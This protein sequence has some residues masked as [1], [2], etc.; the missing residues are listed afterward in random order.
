MG[1]EG[2]SIL[3]GHMDRFAP[4]L[5]EWNMSTVCTTRVNPALDV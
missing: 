4:G 1:V 5:I 3:I 2:V